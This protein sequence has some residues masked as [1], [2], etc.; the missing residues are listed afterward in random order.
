MWVPVL[1]VVL[2]RVLIVV[3]MVVWTM[4]L[5]VVVV[6]RFVMSGQ[7]GCAVPVAALAMA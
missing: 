6:T 3:L 4:L 7:G 1:V 5:V 2:V